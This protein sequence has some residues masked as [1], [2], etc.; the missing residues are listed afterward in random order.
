[1]ASQEDIYSMEYKKIY[2]MIIY[3]ALQFRV[4]DFIKINIFKGFVETVLPGKCY[5]MSY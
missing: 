2:F 1:M 5:K 3:A 4:T